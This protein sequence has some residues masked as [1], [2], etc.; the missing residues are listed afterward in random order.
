[1]NL[2][3]ATETKVAC[4]SWRFWKQSPD[5]TSYQTLLNFS[6]PLLHSLLFPFD[7]AFQPCNPVMLARI[8]PAA[9]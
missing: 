5:T 1:M 3:A 4:F 2:T 7:L 9:K 6:S 8:G